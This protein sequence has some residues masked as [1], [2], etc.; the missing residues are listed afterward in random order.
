GDELL[1]AT[2]DE[3]LALV[4]QNFKKASGKFASLSGGRLSNE[5]FFHIEQL[6]GKLKGKALLDSA[7]AGGDLTA[8]VGVGAG[9][10][11]GDL[12]AGD[13]IFV[14]ASNLEEE[15]PLYWLRVKQ[16]AERG[17]TLIV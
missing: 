5:D 9:S 17:A 6:T 16:A 15:A 2:W 14:I 8:Q 4:A 12:G 10:N 7:M 3:A 13:V 1:P 11:L